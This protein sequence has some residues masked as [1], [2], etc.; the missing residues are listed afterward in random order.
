MANSETSGHEVGFYGLPAI[1]AFYKAGRINI[2]CTAVVT[3]IL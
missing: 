1:D 2:G 3:C